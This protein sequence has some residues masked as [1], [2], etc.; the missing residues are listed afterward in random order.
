MPP[1]D[2]SFTPPPPTSAPSSTAA[3][4]GGVAVEV[5]ASMIPG[6][7]EAM[8]VYTLFASDSTLVDRGLSVVSLGANVLTGGLLPNFGGW[9]KAGRKVANAAEGV[10]DVA[11]AGGKATDIV[12]AGDEVAEGAGAGAK[13]VGTKVSE[14]PP[15]DIK[16]KHKDGWTDAQKAEAEKKAKALSEAD[17]KV[18]KSPER[19]GTTQSRYRKEAGLGSNQD[20]DHIIDLQVGGT[21]TFDNMQGLDTS[22]NRSIGSQIQNQIQDLPDG[23]PLGNFTIE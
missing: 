14:A 13:N 20:A 5:V 23:S 18:V 16:L 17:T 2:G 19:S 10:G 9:L 12:K 6:V 3:Q 21:D 7:G 8:D 11:K 1:D 4:L 22:V 15:V